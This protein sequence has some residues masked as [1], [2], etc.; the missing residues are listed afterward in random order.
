[1]YK[2]N[3]GALVYGSSVAELPNDRRRRW[4][5]LEEDSK[6]CSSQDANDRSFKRTSNPVDGHFACY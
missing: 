1:M 2:S 5:Q 4:Q 3:Q 6:S